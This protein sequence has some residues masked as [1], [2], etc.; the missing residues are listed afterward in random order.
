MKASDYG[1]DA[2][3]KLLLCIGQEIFNVFLDDVRLIP[4][5][6]NITF[7]RFNQRSQSL[8]SWTLIDETWMRKPFEAEPSHTLQF[9]LSLGN[10]A[11]IMY[12]RLICIRTSNKLRQ[13]LR[14]QGQFGISQ[15][16]KAQ[17]VAKRILR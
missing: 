7:D 5:I 14:L 1:A 11:R 10:E 9:D 8:E 2:K 13:S 12:Q 17:S 3:L 4:D 15:D 16:R 6:G